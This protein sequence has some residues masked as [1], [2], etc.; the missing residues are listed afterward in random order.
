MKHIKVFENWEVKAS[1]ESIEP[2]R[3]SGGK[4]D[5][6]PIIGKVIT[7]PIGPFDEG[8]YDIV[9]IIKD[10]RGRDIYIAN[11][12]YKPGVPQLIHSELVKEFIPMDTPIYESV[13]DVKN[14]FMIPDSL[15]KEITG[16]WP[17]VT[18]KTDLNPFYVSEEALENTIELEKQNGIP[19]EFTYFS[20][21]GSY[22]DELI[23]YGLERAESSLGSDPFDEATP[24]EIRERWNNVPDEKK[25]DWIRLAA[26]RDEAFKKFGSSDSEIIKNLN[27][28]NKVNKRWGK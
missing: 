5:S 23:N 11:R 4:V 22:C 13:S 3:W 14:E 27:L 10:P 1:S 18:V 2:I 24:E 21:L 9:E 28:L 6:M 25:V 20:V 19:A 12:W 15:P 17:A 8:E 26:E 16:D 7:K